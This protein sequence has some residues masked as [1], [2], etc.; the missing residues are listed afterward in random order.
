MHSA[1]QLSP[2]AV[3]IPATYVDWC[4]ARQLMHMIAGDEGKYRSSCR[5]QNFFAQQCCLFLHDPPETASGL[6]DK[7]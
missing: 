7:Q 4:N 6:A 5:G 1:E 2:L 3:N